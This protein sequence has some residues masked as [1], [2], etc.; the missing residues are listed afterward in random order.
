[1]RN[2]VYGLVGPATYGT[3]YPA[4]YTVTTPAAGAQQ[5]FSIDGRWQTRVLAAMLSITTDANVADRI[6]SLDYVDNNGVTWLK[7]GSSAL[8][9]ASQTAVQ[10]VWDSHRA[11]SDWNTGT[12]VFVPCAPWF[13]PAGWTIKFAVS[14]IQATDAISG[15]KL[16][17]EQFETGRG[18]YQIGV[19]G[20]PEAT[21]GQMLTSQPAAAYAPRGD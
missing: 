12:P 18:G 6:I 1:V 4:W 16:W 17:V 3:A 14:G 21:P 15:L 8:V 11:V 10:F 13:L 20:E 2:N 5:T 9:P 19:L 7:N